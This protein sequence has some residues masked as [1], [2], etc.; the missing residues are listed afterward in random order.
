M[1]NVVHANFGASIEGAP[2]EIMFFPEGE[3]TIHATING[4][5][6]SAD[7]TIDESIAPAFIEGL[8]ARLDAGGVLP[9]IDFDHDGKVAAGHPVGFRYGD[10]EV[11]GNTKRGLILALDYSDAGI[12]AVKGRN[13]LYFSPSF[14]MEDDGRPSGLPDDDAYGGLV[15][16]PAFREISRI[17][18]KKADSNQTK[19]V[20]SEKLI[21]AANKRATDAENEAREVKAKLA[22]SE[23]HTREVEAKLETLTTQLADQAKASADEKV[24]VH[25]VQA[26]RIAPKDTESIEYWSAALL[27]DK[28]GMALAQLNKLPVHFDP[29]KPVVNA[30]A[31]DKSPNTS[32]NSI[33]VAANKARAEGTSVVAAVQAAAKLDPTAMDE[34]RS[35]LKPA[36][37]E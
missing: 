20:M 27:N 15:N 12:S 1:V 11:D 8:E 6:G 26:G 24:A 35:N 29:I 4:E 36:N 10:L 32:E 14:T 30:S 13:Y 19:T 16:S 37:V 21:E 7:V 5:P 22:E 18:A 34:Y 23:N 3:H 9:F 2:K 25:G 31:G 28:S 17:A 33:L